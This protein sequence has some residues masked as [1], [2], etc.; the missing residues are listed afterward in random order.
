MQIAEIITVTKAKHAR[1]HRLEIEFSDGIR[2]VVDFMPFL[3][4]FRHPAYDKYM[5]VS[6]FKKYKIIGGNINWDDYNMIFPV[7]DLYRGE[8]R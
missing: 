6:G 2:R 5:T 7:E 1:G 4:R 8:I 3:K